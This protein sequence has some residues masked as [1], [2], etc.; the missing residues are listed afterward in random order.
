MTATQITQHPYRYDKTCR[1]VAHPGE[2]TDAHVRQYQEQGYIAVANVLTPG[3]VADAMAGLTHLIC[4]GNAQYKGI[5]FEAGVSVDGLGPDRRELLVRKIMYFVDHEPR[6]AAVARHA[7]LLSMVRKLMGADVLMIQD[8]ALLKPPRVGREKP[9]HQDNAY[10][11]R[12]P[13]DMVIGAWAALDAA[14]PENGCMHVI[15][16]SHL[17]GPRP[18]YHDR[19]CQLPDDEVDLARDVT[20]P[21]EPGGVMFLSALLHHGTP[22]N[23]SGA[24]RRALQFHYASIYSHTIDPA[25]HAEFFTDGRG[26]NGCNGGNQFKPKPI[27]RR[28][29]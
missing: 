4:G 15:P 12:E 10:F 20:V 5:E 19:D 24:R 21:L 3:E 25:R 17:G 22:P 28:N 9:W 14:T 6:L 11:L 27:S 2:F 23:T 8:M 29:F 13:L 16:A 26:Y 18:H 7:T 1:P